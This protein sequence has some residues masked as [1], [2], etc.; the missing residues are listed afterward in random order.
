[1]IKNVEPKSRKLSLGY[2]ET[3]L[4][5][6]LVINV[7][8]KH[9]RFKWLNHSKQVR[10]FGGVLILV[11]GV[12]GFYVTKIMRTINSGQTKKQLCRPLTYDS[13]WSVRLR[14]WA[15]ARADHL[16]EP[17][18][19]WLLRRHADETRATCECWSSMAKCRKVVTRLILKYKIKSYENVHQPITNHSYNLINWLVQLMLSPVFPYRS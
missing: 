9:V 3:M 1:M 17:A 12:L 18:N 5:K 13:N 15:A 11:T 7:A 8:V 6:L 14:W 16:V 2:E 19:C 4:T 10:C